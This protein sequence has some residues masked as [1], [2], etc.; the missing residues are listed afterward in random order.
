[1]KKYSQHPLRSIPPSATPLPPSI[2]YWLRGRDG[3]VTG[4]GG[5]RPHKKKKGEKRKK[6]KK[7]EKKGKKGGKKEKK[8][9]KG[10][11]GGKKEKKGKKE[12]E[13][14]RDL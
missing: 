14:T 4:A 7:K 9:K 11:K 2:P 5:L 3:V 8:E 1:M 13:K 6:R 10:K 12:K